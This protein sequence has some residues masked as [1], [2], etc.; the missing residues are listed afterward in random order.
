V[1]SLIAP[2]N[3]VGRVGGILNF[4]NQLS[5]ICS[6]IITGYLTDSQGSFTAAF[7]VA[8]VLLLIGI[9]AYIFLLGEIETIPDPIS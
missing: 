2:R 6:P 1:P 8:A 5:G 4:G 7:A 9:A 3:S